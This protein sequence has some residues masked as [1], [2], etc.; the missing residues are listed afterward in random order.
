VKLRAL[1]AYLPALAAALI[2][3]GCGGSKS[4]GGGTEK[5]DYDFRT[6]GKVPPLAEAEVDE[7][8]DV[9]EMPLEEGEVDV[10]E[11]EAKVDSTTRPEPP[12]TIPGFRV[13]IFASVSFDTAEGARKAAETRLG[14]PAYVEKADGMFKVRVGDCLTRGDAEAVLKRCREGFYKDAWIVE[15]PVRLDRL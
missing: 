7:A 13:Q 6:E 10:R 15:T 5:G 8:P 4:T 11:A 2:I 9:E 1:C 14:I 3:A 12:T